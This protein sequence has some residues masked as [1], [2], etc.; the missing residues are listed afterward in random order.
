MNREVGWS[1]KLATW[2]LAYRS[3]P[4]KKNESHAWSRTDIQYPNFHLISA[5]P[6]D[7]AEYWW[8]NVSRPHRCTARGRARGHSARP[9][10]PMRGIQ[11]RDLSAELL[12]RMPDR[13]RSNYQPTSST[14]CQA[15]FNPPFQGRRHAR[16][17]LTAFPRSRYLGD[18][19]SR[20]VCL[21]RQKLREPRATR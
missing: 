18:V 12:W 5:T 16:Q 7:T 17:I 10:T 3:K 1:S 15:E 2:C 8:T 19:V 11:P 4:K 6:S 20:D 9:G 21:S 14:P 13:T